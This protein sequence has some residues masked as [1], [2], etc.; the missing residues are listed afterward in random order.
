MMRKWRAVMAAG[1]FCAAA[2]LGAAGASAQG[3]GLSDDSVRALIKYAWVITP[4]KFTMPSGKEIIVDKNKPEAAMVPLETAREVIRVGRLSANA[5]ICGLPEAQA[6]NYQTLMSREQA[7]KKWSDQQLLF[8]NQL[9][10]FTV[11]LMT[12][13]VTVTEEE[14]EKSVSVKDTKITPP[15]GAECTDVERKK[16]EEQITAYINSAPATAEAKN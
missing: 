16:V 3:K 14:G 11:M 6:A 15:T 13:K 1:V 9:H 4:P 12:G 10:L 8:I 2:A 5:Q 7:S